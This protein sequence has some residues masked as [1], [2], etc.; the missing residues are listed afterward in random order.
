M[1]ELKV[2]YHYYLLCV[3]SKIFYFNR[4]GNLFY[5]IASTD[6]MHGATKG[7]A[8]DKLIPKNYWQVFLDK[9]QDFENEYMLSVDTHEMRTS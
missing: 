8:L 4:L 5:F 7:F 2:N 3:P 9:H 6:L 1:R